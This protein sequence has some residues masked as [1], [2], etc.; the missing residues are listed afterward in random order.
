MPA[1]SLPMLPPNRINRPWLHPTCPG[2]LVSMSGPPHRQAVPPP[3]MDVLPHGPPPPH[4]GATTP[5]PY[6]TTPHAPPSNNKC[7]H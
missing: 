2:Q 6:K 5:W 1:P 7:P 3:G 4:P